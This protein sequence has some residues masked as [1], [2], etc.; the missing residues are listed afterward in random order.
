MSWTE[1]MSS[2]EGTVDMILYLTVQCIH[3]C[4]N[5][6]D[7]VRTTKLYGIRKHSPIT[8]QVPLISNLIL[9]THIHILCNTVW[10]Q[11]SA[12]N[13]YNSH[14]SQTD[15]FLTNCIYFRSVTVSNLTCKQH[16]LYVKWFLLCLSGCVIT[17]EFIAV[18]LKIS[19]IKCNLS[20]RAV[21]YRHSEF[22]Y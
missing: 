14:S 18:Y 3:H 9:S 21:T 10:V 16:G 5:Y 15:L 6:S 8:K 11:I 17:I 19:Y 20:I 2:D 12:V 1:V 4:N 22:V 13:I 7:F